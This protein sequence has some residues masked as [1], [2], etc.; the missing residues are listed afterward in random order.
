MRPP[1]Q[2]RPSVSAAGG[3][4]LRSLPACLHGA[5]RE[6]ADSLLHYLCNGK[7]Q[8]VHSH[9]AAPCPARYMP[10]GHLDDVGWQDLGDLVMQ[11]AHSA[12]ALRRAQGGAWLP[13]ELPARRA[14]VRAGRASL[15][16]QLHR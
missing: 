7:A 11:P 16:Q 6:W 13:Q 15:R 14:H 2:P 10:A 9:R 5:H 12:A 1:Q 3:G 4:Q 8:A